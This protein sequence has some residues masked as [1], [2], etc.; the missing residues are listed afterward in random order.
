[1]EEQQRISTPTGIARVIG[2][3]IAH[4]EAWGKIWFGLFFWGA[5]LFAISQRV[6]PDTN[7]TALL[8]GSLLI[9]LASGVAAHI[10]G[11]WL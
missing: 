10:R 5:V 2:G 6:W 4:S 7:N 11:Y 1:V 8:A 3:L 9:G